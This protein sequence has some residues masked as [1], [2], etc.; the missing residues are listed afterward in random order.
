MYRSYDAVNGLPPRIYRTA[1]EIR[2]DI[3]IISEKIECTTQML[4]IRA[5]LVDMLMSE[6]ADTPETLIPDLEEAI[7]EAREALLGLKRLKEELISLEEELGEVR[8]LFGK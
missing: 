7:G 4:N 8:C 1:A 2:G 5:L 3:A 6:R